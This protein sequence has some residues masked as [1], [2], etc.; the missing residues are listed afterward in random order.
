MDHVTDYC[1]HRL[2]IAGA[3]AELKRFERKTDCAD[4]P[5]SSDC[6]LLNRSPGR[7][8]WSFVT[9]APAIAALRALSRRWPQLLFILHYDC[10]DCRTVA[11]IRAKKGRLVQRRIHY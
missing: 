10:E 2:L 6:S 11:L 9:E 8:V 7:V 4:I 3:D 1:T 5:G